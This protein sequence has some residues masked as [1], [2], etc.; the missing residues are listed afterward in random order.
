MDAVLCQVLLAYCD[1]VAR[2][3]SVQHQR[4]AQDLRT[5]TAANSRVDFAWAAEFVRDLKTAQSFSSSPS[6]PTTHSGSCGASS[7]AS[8]GTPPSASPTSPTS[9]SLA[10]PRFTAFS[11]SSSATTCS[12]YVP[13]PK[14]TPTTFRPSYTCDPAQQAL[15][16]SYIFSLSNNITISKPASL[17]N[18][19]SPSIFPYTTP[20]TTTPQPQL[21]AITSPQS[22]IPHLLKRVSLAIVEIK[23]VHEEAS[24]TLR[25]QLR[26]KKELSLRTYCSQ[27]THEI[28]ASKVH[29]ATIERLQ[30]LQGQQVDA[31]CQLD[32]SLSNFQDLMF[33]NLE[34]VTAPKLKRFEL[35]SELLLQIDA[36]EKSIQEI[37]VCACFD[38]CRLCLPVKEAPSSC[39]IVHSFFLSSIME[40]L[41]RA[42]PFLTQFMNLR[43]PQNR[44][45]QFIKDTEPHNRLKQMLTRA[46]VS[47]DWKAFLTQSPIVLGGS[48]KILQEAQPFQFLLSRCWASVNLIDF[49]TYISE[50]IGVVPNQLTCTELGAETAVEGV[51]S[52]GPKAL[53]LLGQKTCQQRDSPYGIKALTLGDFSNKTVEAVMNPKWNREYGKGRGRTIWSGP[54]SNKRY[55]GMRPYFCPIGWKRY[56]IGINNFDE[57]YG[58]WPIAYFSSTPTESVL[59]LKTA[60]QPD[61]VIFEEESLTLYFS[62]SI[63]YTG[64]PMKTRP[65]PI[66]EGH[67]SQMVLMCRVNPAHIHSIGPESLGVHRQA[68]IDTNFN[69]N[70][71]EW[72]VKPPTKN[73]MTVLGESVICYGIMVRQWQVVESIEDGT[74][75]QLIPG[76]D[77]Y[78]L[79][80]PVVKSVTSV[81]TS[82]GVCQIDGDNL[83]SEFGAFQ[84]Q[85]AGR[86]PL[87]IK[88]SIPTKQILV[89][90]PP[91]VGSG[92]LIEI[93][94]NGQV[95]TSQ[96]FSY[97]PP[98]IT[99]IER[100]SGVTS[101]F[102][103]S[104]LSRTERAVGDTFILHGENFGDINTPVCVLLNGYFAGSALVTTPHKEVQFTSLST[105]AFPAMFTLLVDDQFS[106]F[107]AISVAPKQQ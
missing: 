44:Y 104:S 30:T 50:L 11:T 28:T 31:R 56:A 47:K 38:M 63:V 35:Y 4:E 15:S 9:N 5:R 8:D 37:I 107:T 24:E 55:T 85:I 2:T 41:C 60:F 13:T 23:K 36:G 29:G 70:E 78:L 94:A 69:N 21:S 96:T 102:S 7:S 39:Q 18:A 76:W 64:H 46:P 48:M 93:T 74:W 1:H 45:K 19:M 59:I 42:S 105:V 16:T 54:Q 98:V 97:Q 10:N 6:L 84:I 34:F 83:N 71:L 75:W 51:L 101:P 73:H 92:H 100:I 20:N 88:V 90:M 12:S 91:G 67:W 89:T 68:T 77:G 43:P 62:P 26:E 58:T 66:Q 33:K 95:V 53:F 106:D 80:K 81:P 52:G 32:E 99:S 61:D 82:G 3:E 103:N 49:S 86:T 87:H 14:A 72:T 57:K 25:E 40:A 22:I 17:P 65:F 27:T 79:G